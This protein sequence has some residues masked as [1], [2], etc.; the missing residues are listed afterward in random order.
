MPV[1]WIRDDAVYFNMNRLAGLR[2]HT[3][4]SDVFDIFRRELDAAF[5]EGGIFQLTMHP[6]IS[7]YRSRVWILE[8]LIRHARSLGAV[9]FATHADIVRQLPG[10]RGL[11]FGIVQRRLERRESARILASC[12]VRG[13]SPAAPVGALSGGNQQKVLFARTLLCEPRVLIADEPTRGVD[14]GAKRAIY[15]L[16]VALSASGTG[17]LLISSELE[18]ILGLA[19]R[20]VVM[21]RGRVTAEL[22]G[23][24]MTEAA[25]LAAAF[26][27][28]A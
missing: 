18:E 1:E 20:V 6:H 15:D 9:W 11:R 26:Q 16:L 22:A 12:D 17:I 3:A 27:E 7:G 4:P 25:I 21:R 13:A 28:A 10:L 2:P 14:V 5:A 24:E 8:E 23:A 19:H